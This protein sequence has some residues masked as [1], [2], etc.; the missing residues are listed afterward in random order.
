[1]FH[2]LQRL[3]LTLTQTNKQTNRGG[4]SPGLTSAG[5]GSI[6]EFCLTLKALLGS[7]GIAMAAPVICSCMR[8]DWSAATRR[9]QI[10]RWELRGSCLFDRFVSAPTFF[11]SVVLCVLNHRLASLHWTG[12][13]LNI[14]D[15]FQHVFMWVVLTPSECHTVPQNFYVKVLIFIAHIIKWKSYTYYSFIMETLF[16]NTSPTDI[17]TVEYRNLLLW[18]VTLTVVLTQDQ[19][20]HAPQSKHVQEVPGR[21]AHPADG[22]PQCPIFK[23]WTETNKQ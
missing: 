5:T 22:G 4:V 8:R 6:R 23:T 20:V 2:D 21:W 15:N 7:G 3:P 9:Q 19:G 18:T 16:E 14:Q 10:N 12:L 11:I 13:K 17:Y 1:M